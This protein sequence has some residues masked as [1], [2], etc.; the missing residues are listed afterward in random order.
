MAADDIKDLMDELDDVDREME[1]AITLA[2]GSIVTKDQADAL[3]LKY[4][5][6]EQ[7]MEMFR[8]TLEKAMIK[9]NIRKWETEDYI[10]TLVENKPS[11]V[12][13]KDAIAKT[14]EEYLGESIE[15]YYKQ[16]KPKKE[17]KLMIKEKIL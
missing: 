16:S 17:W 5:M 11:K 6:Y 12:L 9:N 2:N 1:G 7:R 15:N 4:F 14:L 8:T 10:V 3:F 13:D